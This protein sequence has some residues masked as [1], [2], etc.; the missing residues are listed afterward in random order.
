MDIDIEEETE[1][2]DMLVINSDVDDLKHKRKEENVITTTESK[3][4]EKKTKEQKANVEAKRNVAYMKQIE[5]S[6]LS[7]EEN[8]SKAAKSTEI[9]R[10][11]EVQRNI[12]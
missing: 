7:D 4:I 2:N 5:E 12:K 10:L 6:I 3:I 1:T 8:I 9:K 11:L